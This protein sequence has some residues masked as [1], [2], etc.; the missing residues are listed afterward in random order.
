MLISVWVSI[1]CLICY[2]T[3]FFRQV[4]EN[5]HVNSFFRTL[6][7]SCLTFIITCVTYTAILAPWRLGREV[8]IEKDFPQLVPIMTLAGVVSFI[9]AIMAMWPVWGFLTPVY[10]VVMFFGYSFS[11][12]FLPSGHLGTLVFYLG[13]GAAA[14][15]SHT[16]PHDPVW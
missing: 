3:N 12:M 14:Y 1:A 16:M 5:P 8:D 9:T 4:W 15:I 11:L 6:S 10:M 2:K 7:L 13:T